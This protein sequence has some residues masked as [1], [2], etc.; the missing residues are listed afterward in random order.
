MSFDQ[1]IGQEE[2]VSVLRGSLASGRPG[3]AYLF[4]GP[5]GTGKTLTA[6]IFAKAVNCELAGADACDRCSS[7][8]RTEHGN[9]PDVHILTPGTE[10]GENVGIGQMRE[11]RGDVH[12]RPSQG[13]RKV[14]IVP[15]ANRLSPPAFHTVLKTLEEPPPYVTIIL[16]TPDLADMLPTVISRCQLVR[17][18]PE[19]KDVVRQA[20]IARKVPDA[21]ATVAAAYTEGRV[22]AALR[23]AE[24]KVQLTRRGKVLELLRILPTSDRAAALRLAEDL[25]KLGAPPRKS[26]AA[27]EKES[28]QNQEG[29]EEEQNGED[30]V[31]EAGEEPKDTKAELQGVLD[32]ALSWYRDLLVVKDAGIEGPVR[33]VDR[34][35]ALQEMAGALSR[36]DAQIALGG[37]LRARYYVERNANPRL[38]MEQVVLALVKADGQEQPPGT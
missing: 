36:K 28:G 8:I 6:H 3:H 37:L 13:R 33:N 4:Y 17:F 25:Q 24:D 35:E 15:E 16:I 11:L 38:V 20:L 9:H 26:K 29:A 1:I 18:T 2:A 22:G 32:V 5:T 12:L 34:L 30:G 31:E 14:Y 7:C 19:P 10:K 21:N 27:R 23:F